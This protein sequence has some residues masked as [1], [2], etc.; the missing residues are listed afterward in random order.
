VA[1]WK[2]HTRAPYDALIDR[3]FMSTALAGSRIDPKSRNS[4]T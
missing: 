1:S 4:T 2:I 3:K